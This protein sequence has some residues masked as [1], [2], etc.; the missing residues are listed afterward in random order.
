MSNKFFF[1]PLNIISKSTKNKCKNLNHVYIDER[2]KLPSC[3]LHLTSNTTNVII[4]IELKTAV[5]ID[6]QSRVYLL[7]TSGEK[8]KKEA[9][10]SKTS[11]Q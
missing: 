1:F 11:K 3:L 8:K 9:G 7:T 6:T 4:N 10:L 5:N 2:C